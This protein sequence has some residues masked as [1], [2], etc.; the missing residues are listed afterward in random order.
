M[1]FGIGWWVGLKG[2]RCWDTGL[3]DT[4]VGGG[5]GVKENCQGWVVEI[6]NYY[7][8][9]RGFFCRILLSLWDDDAHWNW[10]SSAHLSVLHGNKIYNMET[11]ISIWVYVPD[12]SQGNYWV[13]MVGQICACAL[14]SH[15]I[16]S[17]EIDC[18]FP[19]H[20]EVFLVN[21]AVWLLQNYAVLI[22]CVPSY[23]LRRHLCFCVLGFGMKKLWSSGLSR[24]ASS[25]ALEMFTPAGCTSAS[26][27]AVR[28]AMHCPN[29]PLVS[30]NSNAV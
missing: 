27:S 26:A 10:E 22:A 30:V 15:T 7:S 18:T 1:Y 5:W 14:I 11:V 28:I 29:W 16:I 2:Y 9:S 20:V 8:V 4:W 13:S 21:N 24:W 12:V 25:V 6:Y 19:N 23:S 3:W 17:T